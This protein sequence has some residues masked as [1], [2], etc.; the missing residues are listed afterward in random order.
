MIRRRSTPWIHRWSRVLMAVIAT[1]GAI[2]TAFL[3]IVEFTGS[4][5]SVCPTSGCE[6]VLSSPYAQIFGIPLTLFGFLAYTAMAVMAALPLIFNPATQKQE[7]AKWENIT[8]PLMFAGGTAM[9][10]FSGYLMYLLVAV[11]Q[12][13]CPYC[14]A[15]AFFSLS[16]FVLSL[17]GREWEDI[18]QLAFIGIV[19]AMIT[20]IGT[21]GVYA[22]ANAPATPSVNS[23]AAGKAGPP[24]TT[25]SG[26]SEIGLAK[27][28]TQIGA[29]MYG[30][31][32]CPHCHDQ[33]QL[34]GK[35]AFALVDYVECDPEGKNPRP[36]MCVDAQIKGYPSWE[37]NGQIYSGTQS[38]DKLASVS[39]YTGPRT[40]ENRVSGPVAP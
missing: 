33:K 21:L 30:A 32:W 9:V 38:L 7:R 25:K 4:A 5:A 22:N 3:T 2:E 12:A 17:V 1:A 18:G 34:F 6:Q 15:S 8:W 27:H 36:Q 23:S 37:I 31:F 29:K 20:L 24:I 14:L 39:N 35:Q 13:F 16:L 26:E 19:V 11:I 40:F 28:L 10:V